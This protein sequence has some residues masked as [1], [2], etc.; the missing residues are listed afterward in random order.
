MY[1]PAF[2][3]DAEDAT[4]AVN[5]FERHLKAMDGSVEGVRSIFEKVRNARLGMVQLLSLIYVLTPSR[6]VNLPT[7][8][9]LWTSV[10][11]YLYAHCRWYDY[12]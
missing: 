2:N 5:R 3:L 1:H 8:T 4:E 6:D 11:D 9:V 12:N 10:F 7:T